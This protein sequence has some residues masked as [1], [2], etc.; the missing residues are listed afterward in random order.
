MKKKTLKISFQGALGSYSHQAS[1]NF[2]K[3]PLVVPCDSFEE[4][5]ETVRK[6]K[7]DKAILPVDNST[8]GR[9]ADIH[10]LLPA[11]KLFITAEYF[12]PVD[13]CMLGT[14]SSNLKTVTTAT[15]HPVLLGQCK[16]FLKIN[17]IRPISGYDTAG[18]ARLISEENNQFKGALASKIASKIY[19]LKILQANIQDNKDNTTRFLVMEKKP[20]ALINK[21]KRV[22]TS[23]VFQVRNIPAALYKA[24]G[25]FATNNVNMI[26]L[27]SYMLGGSFEATQFFVDIQGHPEDGSVKR[28]LDELRYFTNK[29]DIIGVYKQS[30][31]R[32]KY[33]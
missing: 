11:S 7:A 17:N 24:M 32:Y 13:I 30:S 33:S 3:D 8:Y 1:T 4:A 6:G 9:V 22:I 29:L 25:G 12:L 27:E 20:K 21:Q 16:Q 18:S 19:G 15:S 26:K 28:A 5:I 14:K 31:F 10:S 23:I 2:F